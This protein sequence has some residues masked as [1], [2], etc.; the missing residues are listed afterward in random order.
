MLVELGRRLDE[1]CENFNQQTENIR[2]YQTEVTGLKSIIAKLKNTLEGFNIIL[3]SKDS[4]RD[5]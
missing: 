2:N 5:P 1:R 3:K 4:L